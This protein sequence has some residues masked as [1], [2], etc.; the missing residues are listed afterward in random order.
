M[1]MLLELERKMT[2]PQTEKI[3]ERTE[4]TKGKRE[5]CLLNKGP[6]GQAGSAMQVNKQIQRGNVSFRDTVRI[7]K[8]DGTRK[9]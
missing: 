8:R 4:M 3:S 5:P 6:G 7:Q 9:R 2:R 1:T